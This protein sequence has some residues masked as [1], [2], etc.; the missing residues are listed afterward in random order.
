MNVMVTFLL[1]LLIGGMVGMGLTAI[2][3]AA[4]RADEAAEAVVLPHPCDGPLY[5]NWTILDWMSK[6]HE[7]FKEVQAE[8]GKI[9]IHEG[10]FP[11]LW[12]ELTD[13]ITVCTSMLEATGCDYQ[14]RQAIQYKTNESNATRDDGMRFKQGTGTT[15]RW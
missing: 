3:T 6:V 9:V 2:F 4:K 13:L 1:G 12:Y 8:A 5:K 14:T 11:K 7:E 10:I 15:G